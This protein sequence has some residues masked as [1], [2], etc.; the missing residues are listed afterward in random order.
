MAIVEMQ[1]PVEPSRDLTQ[2]LLNVLTFRRCFQD[3]WQTQG[4]SSNRL[5]NERR[6]LKNDCITTDVYRRTIQMFQV[7]FELC[8]MRFVAACCPPNSAND[9]K[10]LS[11]DEEKKS[12]PHHLV[13]NT[14][15]FSLD[16]RNYLP[17][18]EVTQKWPQ[19]RSK[20]ILITLCT[21][22]VSLKILLCACFLYDRDKIM[23][24]IRLVLEK[25]TTNL[26]ATCDIR[27][28]VWNESGMRQSHKQ[29]DYEKLAWLNQMIELVYDDRFNMFPGVGFVTLVIIGSAPLGFY[30]MPNMFL[31]L[32]GG[33][34]LDFMAFI[35][36]PAAEERRL[37]HEINRI[38]ENILDSLT[39]RGHERRGMKRILVDRNL[40]E[41]YDLDYRN[42]TNIRLLAWSKRIDDLHFLE[43]VT[44]VAT[45]N[46]VRPVVVHSGWHQD[47]VQM[48]HFLSI[49]FI[50]ISFGVPLA[51][52]LALSVQE[53]FER[54]RQ[55]LAWAEC[56]V[57]SDLVMNNYLGFPLITEAQHVQAYEGYDLTWSYYL[58]LALK[59]ELL[60]YFDMKCFYSQLE[61]ATI[62]FFLSVWSTLITL[63]FILAYLHKNAW[64]HQ[65]NNQLRDCLLL[66]VQ[67][68]K[69]VS[70]SRAG[71]PVSSRSLM[72]VNDRSCYDDPNKLELLRYLTIV[73]INYELFRRQHGP[74]HELAS[75][76]V[77][78]AVVFT[79]TAAGACYLVAT[80]IATTYRAPILFAMACVVMFMNIYLFISSYTSKL[81][82]RIM[83]NVVRLMAAMA[84]DL[85][86]HSDH[87]SHLMFS[88]PVVLWRR[89]L[90]D[91]AE[92]QR[93]AAV[94]VLGMFM[95]YEKLIAF[96]VYLVAIFILMSK[97]S[98]T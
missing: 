36:T 58:Y 47:L 86:E 4:Q 3:P 83:F 50:A 25:Q 40:N 14:L 6:I 64:L 53:I 75:F 33:I 63:L 46:Q 23:K 1:P 62:E 72:S 76:L 7:L 67:F 56:S 92:V 65:I 19:T 8:S 80:N 68:N 54:T 48:L 43:L 97:I 52:N 84:G 90:L 73:Y 45:R 32:R 29:L 51:S 95:S 59:V 5:E 91:Q 78:Q 85:D 37:R 66:A 79:S 89:Q 31:H 20:F 35:Y 77:H 70:L 17:S 21:T 38:V 13:P 30:Y 22:F 15:I 11:F 34:R 55:R 69:Q 28:S 10:L 88:T 41:K 9:K 60:Y 57:R 12:K 82:E 96:N 26:T 98:A 81:N 27:Q 87:S 18:A 2:T 44:R 42:G 94:N 24:T 39:D 93:F 16:Q 61:L 74:V 49:L 71:T